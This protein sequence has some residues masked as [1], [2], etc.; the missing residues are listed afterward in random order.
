MTVDDV[1]KLLSDI[2]N[3]LKVGSPGNNKEE[4]LGFKDPLF[5]HSPILQRQYEELLSKISNLEKENAE[6]K[7]KIRKNDKKD[8]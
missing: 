8:I 4:A 2:V 1:I 3:S 5:D 7:E 6:L